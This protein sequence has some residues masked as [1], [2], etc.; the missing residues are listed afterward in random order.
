MVT[1]TSVET[2]AVGSVGVDRDGAADRDR[3][4]LLIDLAEG[5]AAE[6]DLIRPGCRKVAT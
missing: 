2:V 5:S 6:N 4:V 1:T 3:D